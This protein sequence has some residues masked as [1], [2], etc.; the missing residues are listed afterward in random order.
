MPHP[1]PAPLA[2][3]SATVVSATLLLLL[4]A[5]SGSLLTPLLIACAALPLG[6]AVTLASQSRRDARAAAG[7]AAP[8]PRSGPE[9]RGAEATRPARRPEVRV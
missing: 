4:L 2:Y 7:S 8:A 1:S 5:P 3:G 9:K 6:V